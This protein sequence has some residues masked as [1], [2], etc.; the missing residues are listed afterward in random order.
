MI[1]DKTDSIIKE[2]KI[3]AKKMF[4]QNFLKSKEILFDI[5]KAAEVSKEDCVIEI[6]PGL[7]ALTELLCE[8]AHKVI[9]YEI[10]NILSEQL[11]NRL[12]KYT[13]YHIINDDFLKCDIKKDI[14]EYFD[15][16]KKVKVVANIPYN[17]T[18][19]IIQKLL[20]IKC[21]E[22]FVL[23]VQKELAYRFT[24]DEGNKEYG[25]I[26]AYIKH[27]GV[28]RLYKV[29]NRNCFEPIPN[30]D[31]AIFVFNRND[32]DVD[33][34]YLKFLRSAFAQKR[35]NIFNNLK[36]IYGLNKD[37]IIDILNVN[38][39]PTSTRTEQLSSNRLYDLYRYF[40]NYKS[41]I[42]AYAK[43]NLILRILNK[44]EDGYHILE[45][46][47]T[48]IDLYDEI[49]IK[50]A[51]ADSVKMSVN[52][53]DEKDNLVYKALSLL[54][55]KYELKFH[56]K[57]FI[58]KKIPHGAGLAGG[59]SDAAAVIKQI[60]KIES[61]AYNSNDLNEL[62]RYLGAD[63]PYCLQDN[64]CVVRGI[65]EKLTPIYSKKE[66]GI[67]LAC[68]PLLFDTKKMFKEYD[69]IKQDFKKEPKIKDINS[70]IDDY[71]SFDNDFEEVALKIYFDYKLK[72]I[73]QIAKDNGAITC[74]MT[75]S[76]SS[77]Y[78]LYDLEDKNIEKCLNE[79]KEKIPE[80]HFKKYKTISY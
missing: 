45:M 5:V 54:R 64:K 19:P 33:E 39:I 20:E 56:Y 66:Y 49:E 80:Y 67:I 69:L 8:K 21:I 74:H 7:G 11:P 62:T 52:L 37:E 12:K 65:G 71:D 31:S 2:N 55:S 30:V 14:L 35:K 3:H 75:G 9:C 18:T 78:V 13:N 47:N 32:N 77:I 42:K 28:T 46:L 60:L 24:C 40:K 15:L 53:C 44:Q 58:N 63:I 27:L 4:G 68:T 17:I 1:V 36:N 29:V 61:I 70:V 79:L 16:E 6:G 59:S 50:L 72:E 34:E 41:N 48:K 73:K 22:V 51:N 25:S 76:G 43:L 10:D 26:T 23:M 57:V 38:N